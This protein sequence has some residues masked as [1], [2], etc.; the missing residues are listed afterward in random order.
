[1]GLSLRKRVVI[2]H[3]KLSLKCPVLLKTLLAVSCKGK[4]F[5]IK[6]ISVGMKYYQILIRDSNSDDD[7]KRV[8]NNN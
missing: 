5:Q 6:I 3:E 1:M 8:I 7:P 4:S 2:M